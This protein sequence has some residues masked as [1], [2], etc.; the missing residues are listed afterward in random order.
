VS[1][2]KPETPGQKS[3]RRR[4]QIANREKD[5]AKLRKKYKHDSAY[6]FAKIEASRR[7]THSMTTH[8]RGVQSERRC[9]K[10]WR[11]R[12]FLLRSAWPKHE[13]EVGSVVLLSELMRPVYVVE[14]DGKR[15]I[16]IWPPNDLAQFWLSDAAARQIVSSPKS[17]AAANL[18][19]R[20][21]ARTPNPQVSNKPL[22][23]TRQTA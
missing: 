19:A 20:C 13:L 16:E 6:R 10:R 12:Q 15:Q 3:R 23:T 4:R 14:L 22:D 17:A 11:D 21:T 2:W 18:V 5:N 1:R 8:T 9:A 7:H